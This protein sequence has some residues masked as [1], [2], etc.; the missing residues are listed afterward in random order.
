MTRLLS[1]RTV[2]VIRGRLTPSAGA[3]PSGR[4]AVKR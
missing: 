3:Y 2:T 4:A 1:A